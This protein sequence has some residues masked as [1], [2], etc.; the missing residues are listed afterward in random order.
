MGARIGAGGDVCSWCLRLYVDSLTNPLNHPDKF[1]ISCLLLYSVS[2]VAVSREKGF[3]IIKNYCLQT[4]SSK[5]TKCWLSPFLST[6]N[7]AGWF[8]YLIWT[9]AI[10]FLESK[11]P[12]VRWKFSHPR[13]LYWGLW[14]TVSGL[15]TISQV[16]GQLKDGDGLL[17]LVTGIWQFDLHPELEK[18]RT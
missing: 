12:R 11:H 14:L 9:W 6:C 15:C 10:S 17:T 18:K 5:E 2:A 1:I 8:Y 7:N 4:K 3:Y 13:V 16:F